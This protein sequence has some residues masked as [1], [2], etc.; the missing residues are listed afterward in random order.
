MT[1]PL[2]PAL[3]LVLIALCTACDRAA[4]M[5]PRAQSNGGDAVA[6]F[7]SGDATLAYQIDFPSGSGPFPGV[8][9]GHGSGRLTREHLRH[10]ANQW[11]L[12]GFAV[13]RFDKRGVGQS[14]GTYSGMGAGNSSQLVEILAGD[15]V[16]AVRVLRARPEVDRTRVGISG[17][18][19]A[20]WILPAAARS[21][22]DAA[23]M[24][25][26]SGPV[27]TVGEEMFY[28]DLAEKTDAPLDEVYKQMPGFRGPHGFDPVPALEAINT[29][30]LWLLGL[31]DR[32]IPIRTTLAN[33]KSL[34]AS[35]K[36]FEWRT[37]DGLGHDLNWIIWKDI[38]PWV[39]RFKRP[40]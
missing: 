1:S 12:R 25:L 9:L 3:A 21:L 29:P 8:V 30:T 7:V 19:Q 5:S 4:G 28:S 27:C 6:T 20:G 17:W 18:S 33:L 36:P 38:E 10:F 31:D 37:Y 15:V 2:R 13:L 26:V 22:G 40:S 16:A 14:T 23:F 32:S 11:T 34:A 24:V 35:G 39:Q